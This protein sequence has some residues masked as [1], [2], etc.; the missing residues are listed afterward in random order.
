MGQFERAASL[1]AWT[2]AMSAQIG[3]IRPPVEQASIERELEVIHAHIDD[4]DFKNSRELGKSM[5][6]S[7]AI[8]LALDD[9][10][11]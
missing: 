2:D 6:V 9:D 4:S 7:Q 10:L 3:D 11:E 5:S 8:A 1:F